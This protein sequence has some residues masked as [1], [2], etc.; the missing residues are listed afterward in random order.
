MNCLLFIQHKTSKL[1]IPNVPTKALAQD[2]LDPTKEKKMNP[3][4]ANKALFE[5]RDIPQNKSEGWSLR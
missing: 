3:P 1:S 5:C 4:T 2:E